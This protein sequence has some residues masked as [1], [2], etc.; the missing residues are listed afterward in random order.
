VHI[1]RDSHIDNSIT[2]ENKDAEHHVEAVLSADTNK[3][4][5]E[6]QIEIKPEQQVS[7][8]TPETKTNEPHYQT[9]LDMS[10]GVPVIKAQNDDHDHTHIVSPP[11]PL[12]SSTLSTTI[13]EKEL[14]GKEQENVHV[15]HVNAHERES[16]SISEN[17]PSNN[18]PVSNSDTEKHDHD[19]HDHAHGHHDHDHG[20]HDHD[21]SHDHSNE[22]TQETS[23]IV[24]QE[25]STE[26]SKPH[27]HTETLSNILRSATIHNKDENADKQTTPPLPEVENL[28]KE[29]QPTSEIN[30]S[31]QNETDDKQ[32]ENEP[33]KYIKTP[34]PSYKTNRSLY[35]SK[36]CADISSIR[37]LFNNH[38][39][40]IYHPFITMLPEDFQVMLLDETSFGG[41]TFASC[42]LIT[43]IVGSI[44]VVWLLL[45]KKQHDSETKTT[46]KFN[47][48]V[49]MLNNRVKTLTFEKETFES[50]VNTLYDKVNTHESCLVER[51]EKLN[52]S[53]EKLAQLKKTSDTYLKELEKLRG[54]ETKCVKELNQYKLEFNDLTERFTQQS[55][56]YEAKLSY[57]TQ[58]YNEKLNNLML[59][60]NAKHEELSQCKQDVGEKTSSL[61]LYRENEI[62]LNNLIEQHEKKILILQNSLLRDKKHS[63]SNNSLDLNVG[64]DEYVK[65][66]NDDLSSTH[67]ADLNSIMK[68]AE[69]Q[70]DIKN[71]EDRLNE[72]TT[73]YDAK[74]NECLSLM[75]QLE[76]R[77]KYC[78]QFK[79]RQEQLEKNIKDSEI[80][81]K[82]L[83]EL[84][85][86]D[87]KQ[88]VKSLTE[89]DVQLKKKTTDA[90]KVSH[91]LDQLR[92]KQERIH[93]LESQ[94]ARIEKQSS[95]E[96]QTFEKQAHENWLNAKRIDKE[97][98]ET[99]NETNVLKEKLTEL[100]AIN[101]SLI[102][103]Q[104]GLGPGLM[105]NTR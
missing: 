40:P 34:R 82:V 35:P 104:N 69:L 99:R 18:P 37:D 27:Q 91:L 8:S 48:T 44:S 101:K 10:F 47:E 2:H 80:K 12:S 4:T 42:L 65:I 78:E 36:Y 89:L 17:K 13:L 85:E 39:E 31:T 72:T 83:N 58:D 87:T 71:L 75:A 25:E 60:L 11:P 92:V 105:P 33:I 30:E 24:T 77:E 20:H 50:E 51:D 22:N 55:N 19:H 21:H 7:S 90:E 97:L 6:T 43:F 73:N 16:V 9:T 88:H 66:N 57:F 76:E 93:E 54:S 81:I 67:S 95:Q 41:L 56:E 68:N 32:L 84:R 96:R 79:L 14:L 15:D 102:E 3:K 98:K 64:G 1:P 74:V 5:D 53:M 103:R 46:I 94:F 38:I 59:E 63:S 62:Q 100:E 70:M 52:E 61:E 86:K 23:T 28:V 26:S 45:L 29:S 49:L